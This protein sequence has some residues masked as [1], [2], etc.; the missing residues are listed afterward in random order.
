MLAYVF[1]HE[2]EALNFFG[3]S[4]ARGPNLDLLTV[5]AI[6]RLGREFRVD[7]RNIPKEGGRRQFP[8]SLWID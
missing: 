4:R 7:R 6:A 5:G 3:L 8:S 1:Y 2:A